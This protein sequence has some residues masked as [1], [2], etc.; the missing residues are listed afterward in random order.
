MRGKGKRLVLD[1]S[2][3]ASAAS[4][5]VPG[6]CAEVCRETLLAVGQLH[7]IVFSQ[8]GW[9]EWN[10]HESRFAGQ[11]RRQMVARRKVIF[12]AEEAVNEA[13]REALSQVSLPDRARRAL[14]KDAH[15]AEA[16][17]ATDRIIISRDEKVRSYFLS[18]C[19]EVHLL[20]EILWANPEIETEEVVTWIRAGARMERRRKLG[21]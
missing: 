15:L 16:A 20:K 17:N 6:A 13:F 4:S 1:A 5:P 2:V 14:V 3:G 11:W 21:R 9:E 12:L 8:E 19:S 18:V 10:R 7:R